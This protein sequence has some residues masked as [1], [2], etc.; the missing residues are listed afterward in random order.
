M[1]SGTTGAERVAKIQAYVEEHGEEKAAEAFCLAAS[2]IRRYCFYH[3]RNIDP[4]PPSEVPAKAPKPSKSL[5]LIE[6]RYSAKE[7]AMLARGGILGEGVSEK[8]IHNFTGERIRLGVLSDTHFGSKY[9]DPAY[10]QE[11]FKEFREFGV[12]LVVISG[13]I[14]EGV[15]HRPGHV[16]ECTHVGV[17]AQIKHATEVLG[18]WQD[19]PIDMIS[20]NHDEWAFKAA[21]VDP[22]ARIAKAIGANYLGSHEGDIVLGPVKV[23]LWHGQDGSSYA[24]SYR[25]QKVIEAFTGGDK[26]DVLIAGHVHKS[27]YCYDRHVHAL[28]AGAIQKQSK[29]MR[30]KR[31]PSHTG[32][33][34]IELTMNDEGVG[35]FTPTWFPFY[36]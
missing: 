2:T 7:L 11:A 14:T 24:H 21:G 27:L 16:Y 31:L 26:P 12:D 18:S 5:R 23:R 13:D 3:K 19:S 1:G 34:T 25:I 30:T 8:M 29:W 20:G 22:V 35:R 32:F 10:L 6:E 9:T 36:K 28:S 4:N 17:D 33:W 15:S